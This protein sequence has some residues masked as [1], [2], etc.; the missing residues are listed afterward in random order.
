MHFDIKKILG[1]SANHGGA[2]LVHWIC[3]ILLVASIQVIQWWILY[4]ISFTLKFYF[5]RRVRK[6]RAKYASSLNPMNSNTMFMTSMLKSSCKFKNKWLILI[7][8][9]GHWIT[10]FHR[11]EGPKHITLIKL[12]PPTPSAICC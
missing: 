3:T 12:L 4:T 10:T 8:S 1:L 7:N 9:D 5:P 6:S 2:V 11:F